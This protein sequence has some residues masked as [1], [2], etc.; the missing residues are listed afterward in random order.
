MLFILR[1]RSNG[2][3][4]MQSYCDQN[5]HNVQIARGKNSH[6]VTTRRVKTYE[7]H[8][9]NM[10]VL[11]EIKSITNCLNVLDRLGV[12]TSMVSGIKYKLQITVK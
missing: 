12:V 5:N 4:H 9:V 3:G 8:A 6:Y 7:V 2:R 1:T 11:V 10:W